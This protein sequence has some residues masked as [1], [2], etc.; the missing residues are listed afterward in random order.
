[1]TNVI[2]CNKSECDIC[3]HKLG[4]MKTDIEQPSDIQ[5]LVN[6]F[7][8]NVRKDPVIGDIFIERI[9]DWSAHLAKMYRFWETVLLEVHS[10]SGS[11]F[12]PHAQMS[13]TA[14][15]FDRWL[16][17]WKETVNM[18]FEGEKAK[19]A[20]WRGEAMAAMFLSKIEFYRENKLKPL[21]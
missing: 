2:I 6:E 12:P 4:K 8:A 16:A 20:K 3:I 10:Y 5:K 9:T 21:L 14:T 19:E 15:H 11:P 1:M 13:L 18:Y 7:Y 17:I